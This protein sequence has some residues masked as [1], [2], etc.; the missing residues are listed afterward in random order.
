MQ[1]TRAS[2]FRVI[3]RLA[4]P[5]FAAAVSVLAFRWPTRALHPFSI[6]EP[7]TAAAPFTA[8]PTPAAAVPPPAPAPDAPPRPFEAERWSAIAAEHD[9]LR[10]ANQQMALDNDRLRRQLNDLLR[11]ILDNFQ[12][13][14]PIPERMVGRLDVPAVTDDFRVHD[15]LAELL[16]LS[17]QERE[18]LDDAFRAARAMAEAAELSVMRPSMP[19]PGELVIEIPPHADQGREIRAHLLAAIESALGSNRAPW[20]A[21]AAERDLDR[22]FHGFG[23]DHRTI[24]MELV[25]RP[26]TPEPWIRI[27]DERA[28][29][30][31][32]GRVRRESFEVTTEALPAEYQ[33][34]VGR[35]PTD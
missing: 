34:Y 28:M 6:A 35:L 15:D 26:D 20:A 23:A 18:R 17:P 5:V 9:A 31:G 8:P 19:S 32:D 10:A 22:R 4:I 1:R 7:H 14:Y 27:T 24:R 12:G 3:R 30:V 25:Y 29:V 33:P 16:R 2:R 11:W 13:R 21:A